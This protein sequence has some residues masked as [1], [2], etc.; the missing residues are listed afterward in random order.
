MKKKCF[1]VPAT[2]QAVSSLQ[3][4]QF[5]ARKAGKEIQF[6][7]IVLDNQYGE[8][9][10]KEMKRTDV[11]L[12]PVGDI[13]SED[14]RMAFN[15]NQDLV[16]TVAE[17][18]QLTQ[19]PVL[20]TILASAKIYE[21]PTTQEIVSLVVDNQGYVERTPADINA[22]MK[23]YCDMQD[24]MI[25]WSEKVEQ[26]AL[27]LFAPKTKAYRVE[28]ITTDPGFLKRSV[29]VGI[30]TVVEKEKGKISAEQLLRYAPRGEKGVGPDILV[31]SNENTTEMAF[32]PGAQSWIPALLRRTE[33]CG[34][35]FKKGFLPGGFVNHLEFNNKTASGNKFTADDFYNFISETAKI[36]EQKVL[37]EKV[38]A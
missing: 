37:N 4:H 1:L 30:A 23:H 15:K 33:N 31:L 25:A 18:L 38:T 27:T 11:I 3:L 28:S 7:I 9:I 21:S 32:R 13:Y 24:Q 35:S 19:N 22:Q 5:A 6:V 14:A 26:F 29:V 2:T 12:V 17:T 16:Q 34:I 36:A 8:K 20:S 10:E